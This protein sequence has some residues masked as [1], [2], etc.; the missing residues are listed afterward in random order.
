M[1]IRDKNPLTKAL[2]TTLRSQKGA[3][4]KAAAKGLNRPRRI[5]IQVNL[6]S[7]ERSDGK[8]T[9]LVPGKVL[10]SGTLTKPLQ[11]AALQFTAEARKKIAAAGGKALSVDDLLKANPTGKGVQVIG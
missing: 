11:I 5:K 9:I 10:G 8:A 7:L 6:Y 2:L 1:K 4:W 3:A